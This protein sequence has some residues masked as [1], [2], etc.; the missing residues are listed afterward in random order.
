MKA[1]ARPQ[2]C[3]CAAL[4]YTVFPAALPYLPD[5]PCDCAVLFWRRSPS[6]RTHSLSLEK[7]LF[8]GYAVL[9]RSSLRLCR[10][11]SG[12]GSPRDRPRCRCFRAAEK[13]CGRSARQAPPTMKRP[14]MPEKRRS[15]SSGLDIED[16][17]ARIL[18]KGT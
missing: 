5:L 4:F 9:F 10:V 6:L 13:R 3:G 12:G 16:T 14:A 15:A 18:K 8:A 11:L 7:G 1:T 17:A 2:K